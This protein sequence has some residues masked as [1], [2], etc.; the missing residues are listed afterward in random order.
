MPLATST[1]SLRESTKSAVVWRIH[2]TRLAFRKAGK[3][4]RREGK[5]PDENMGNM[6]KFRVNNLDFSTWYV[7]LCSVWH[8]TLSELVRLAESGD[9]GS[10]EIVHK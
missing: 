3:A 4:L 10:P 2:E 5:L 7:P 9:G 6:S 8:C 1:V